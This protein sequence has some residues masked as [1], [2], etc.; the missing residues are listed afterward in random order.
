MTSPMY[1]KCN[2]KGSRKQCG[3][4]YLIQICPGTTK[5][6]VVRGGTVEAVIREQIQ[7]LGPINSIWEYLSIPDGFISLDP[8]RTP[9]GPCRGS[10]FLD[11]SCLG[12]WQGA[13][14]I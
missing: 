3:W 2:V 6:G 10:Y 13:W 4:F 7:K 1:E 11:R 8:Y 5:C 12:I 9:F 14:F